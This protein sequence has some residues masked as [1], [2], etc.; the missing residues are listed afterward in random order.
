MQISSLPDPLALRLL[1]TVAG[2][3]L[4]AAAPCALSDA[5][6]VE[7]LTDTF[8][9][10]AG[11]ALSDANLARAALAVAAEE[12]T[13]CSA[14]ELLIERGGPPTYGIVETAAVLTAAL[15]ILQTE[16]TFERAP[17][18]KWK[19]KLHKKAAS[20]ALLKALAQGIARALGGGSGKDAAPRLGG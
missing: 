5:D 18:G 17:S 20:D 4:H 19:V 13:T 11:P 14:I 7:A 2:P 3:R 8:G 1:S 12:P 16:V 9:P 6:L 15:A 10:A